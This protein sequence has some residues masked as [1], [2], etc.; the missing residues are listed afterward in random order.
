VTVNL[1][2]SSILPNCD[3]WITWVEDLVMMA[4]HRY[5]RIHVDLLNCKTFRLF[6]NKTSNFITVSGIFIHFRLKQNICFIL[7]CNAASI[8]HF[9]NYLIIS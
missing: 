7:K 6:V 3:F 4:F 1:V 8:K 5:S 9:N 2:T